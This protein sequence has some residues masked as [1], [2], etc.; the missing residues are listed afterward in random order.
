MTIGVR[1]T[2]V[3]GCTVDKVMH[4]PTIKWLGALLLGAAFCAHAAEPW[5]RLPPTPNMPPHT[6]GKHVTVN[7]A[8]LWYAEWGAGNPGT[9]VL[10][11][12]GGYANSNYFG[13]LVPVLIKNG[14]HVIA[15]DSRGHGRSRRTD[16][17][18]TYHLMASDFVG[19]L[20]ALK[21]K[22]VSL[23]GWSDGGCTGYDLAINYPD[24]L[25]RIFTFGSNADV[26]GFSDDFDKN[27]VV[28]AYLAR[29][30][31]EYRRLSPT[32][33]DWESFNAAM[34]KM[35]TTLP[36]YTAEQLHAVRVHTTISD[37]QFD[38]GMKPEH[39]RYLVAAIPDARLVIL[40]NLSHFAMLQ[41]PSAFNSA[42]LDFL[43]DYK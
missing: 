6:V 35:W 38:E 37:G 9:P 31:E 13:F 34:N 27:P 42:V 11:L 5:K 18:I 16:D 17:A 2:P 7:G 19:L 8:R 12:H 21:V 43:R 40:P 28:V 4:N 10:L 39:L 25:E 20:D 36:T 3:F 26:A 41:D 22:K 1:S 15:V 32:P 33:N 24:R 14:Y 23:V 30:R 29:T